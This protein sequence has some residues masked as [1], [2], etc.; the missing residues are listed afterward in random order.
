MSASTPVTA[1]NPRGAP[2]TRTRVIEAPAG[3][4]TA[5]ELEFCLG[6][7]AAGGVVIVPTDTVYGIA[8]NA[9]DPAAVEKVYRLKGRDYRKPLPV[10]LAD[11]RELP[12][13][14]AD[15]PAEAYRLTAR[16]W[17]G[18]LTLVLK[19]APTAVHAARGRA[20][21]A[22]RVPDHGTIVQLLQ[23]A[24]YPL[25]VTSANRSGEPP[26]IDG[27]AVR[28]DFVGTV[29]AIVDAGRCR[30]GT[31]SSVVDAS[32]FPFTLLRAG[33]VEKD[34]LDAYLR[35]ADDNLL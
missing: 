13:I 3:R 11:A 9:F 22:V 6:V 27:D 20:T 10:L 19:T 5:A 34:R 14:A 12:R 30:V 35:G 26:L 23:A 33:A 2:V 4:L 1:R 25:A 8:C 18:P 7:F 21:I 32:Q 15:V 29:E 31:A 16:L 28:R 24:P 17:P